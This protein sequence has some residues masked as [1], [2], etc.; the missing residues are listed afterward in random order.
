MTYIHTDII[1]VFETWLYEL[2]VPFCSK[3]LVTWPSREAVRRGVIAPCYAPLLSQQRW[4]HQSSP[5]F[6]VVPWLRLRRAAGLLPLDG[7][8]YRKPQL[9]VEHPGASASEIFETQICLQLCGIYIY[10]YMCVCFLLMITN[11][12]YWGSLAKLT[13]I[14]SGVVSKPIRC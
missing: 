6:N 11:M 2:Y 5:R 8:E 13:Q 14:D 4:L 1:Y 12:I 7:Q 9:Y 10:N 3:N